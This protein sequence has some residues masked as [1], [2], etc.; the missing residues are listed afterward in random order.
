[1]YYTF[2]V[3]GDSFDST[4]TQREVAAANFFKSCLIKWGN[5]SSYSG[6]LVYPFIDVRLYWEH[7]DFII[8]AYFINKFYGCI[9]FMA[10]P[11]W[12]EEKMVQDRRPIDDDV[13]KW[14]E[15][16]ELSEEELLF[17]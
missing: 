3:L 12:H 4:D 5:P 15:Q 11:W 13:M 6:Q 16:V 9:T 14:L 2:P 10:K 1:M 17:R 7:D 8:M